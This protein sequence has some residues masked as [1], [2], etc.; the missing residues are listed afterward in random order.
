MS[1][2]KIIIYGNSISAYVA[3]IYTITANMPTLIIQPRNKNINL[4]NTDKIIGTNPDNE[5]DY[6]VIKFTKQQCIDFKID[7]IECDEEIKLNINDKVTV[8]V[9]D[10]E[11]E[12]DCLISEY[13][14]NGNNIINGCNI[15]NKDG[16]LVDKKIFYCG[17]G[18]GVM[19]EGIV[20]A[21]SGCM[22]ALEAKDFLHSE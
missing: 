18:K 11:Y 2:Y 9:E 14:L 7:M 12:V 5:K 6:D 17:E 10:K 1:N 3:G 4:K 16:K 19:Y 13:V 21:G 15:S 22:A 8:K 20:M